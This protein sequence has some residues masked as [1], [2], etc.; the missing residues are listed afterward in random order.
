M[1]EDD[2]GHG[3]P[4][5][6]C[7]PS[8]AV[9]TFTSATSGAPTEPVRAAEPALPDQASEDTDAAWGDYPERDDDRLYRDRPP[10]WD[11]F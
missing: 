10:H 2:P 1:T 9:T 6:E 4:A 7:A 3:Q 5:G 8:A 11:D